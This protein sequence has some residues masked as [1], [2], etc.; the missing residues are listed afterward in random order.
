MLKC[1]GTGFDLL[2]NVFGAGAKKDQ[3]YDGV[4]ASQSAWDSNIV[5]VN[6]VGANMEIL[7]I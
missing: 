5:K 4:K 3:C 1:T 2:R 7:L 6:P